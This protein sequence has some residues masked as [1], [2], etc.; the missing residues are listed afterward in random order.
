MANNRGSPL[1][2]AGSKWNLPR[3]FPL[4]RICRPALDT[5]E[6]K[7]KA[8]MREMKRSLHKIDSKINSLRLKVDV[9]QE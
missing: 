5:P 1:K 8:L 3:N 2:G 7:L 9:Y 4:Q 6:P